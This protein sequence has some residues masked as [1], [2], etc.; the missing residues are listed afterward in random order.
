MLV[1]GGGQPP[2]FREV[3]VSMFQVYRGSGRPKP[4][5]DAISRP[6]QSQT[7]PPL[8]STEQAGGQ[9]RHMRAH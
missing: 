1:S 9:G 5:Q 4:T 8:D 7:A 3:A 6:W 2:A